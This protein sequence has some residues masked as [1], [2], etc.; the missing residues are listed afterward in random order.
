MMDFKTLIRFVKNKI[1]APDDSLDYPARTKNQIKFPKKNSKIKKNSIMPVF[2]YGVGGNEMV[3]DANE[4]IQDIQ[5]NKTL[6]VSKLTEDAPVSP[7]V[8]SGLD[9]VEDVFKRFQ[10][11]V[12]VTHETDDGKTVEEEFAFKNL[13]DFS[14]KTLIQ[15]S[16]FLKNLSIEQEQYNNI[17][18]L[19]KGHKVLRN[20]L[21]DSQSRAAFIDALKAVA[22][23][24]EN[25]NNNHH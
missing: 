19:L 10:P 5:E 12:S 24:L 2:N 4:A 25:N 17:I 1:R 21:T 22:T 16:S 9:T 23:E 11:S 20:V 13:A 7:E 15:H 14:P 8:V 6:I 3:V 18:R